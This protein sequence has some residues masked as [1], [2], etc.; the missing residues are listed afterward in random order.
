MRYT[1]SKTQVST[2]AYYCLEMFLKPVQCSRETCRQDVRQY[3]LNGEGSRPTEGWLAQLGYLYPAGAEDGITAVTHW[4]CVDPNTQVPAHLKPDPEPYSADCYCKAGP[5]WY[6]LR[7]SL[8][9][10]AQMMCR[11]RIKA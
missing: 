7:C 8:L 9:V 1:V 10:H 5:V 4:V 11:H 3:A 2:I 6:M